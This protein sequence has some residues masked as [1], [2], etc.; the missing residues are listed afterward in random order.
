MNKITLRIPAT[1][2]N[3]GPGFDC[4]GLALNLYNEV[5]YEIMDN[6]KLELNVEGEGAEYM[7]PGGFNLAFSSFFRVWNKLTNGRHIG[8]KLHQVNRIPM[9]RGLGSSSAAIV[10]GV[11]AAS[12]LSDCNLPKDELLRFAN[13]LEGHPDNVAPAIYGNFTISFFEPKGPRSFVLRPAKPLKFIACVPEMK[14]STEVARKAIP[15]KINHKD[16][17]VNAS[18]TALLVAALTSGQYEYLPTAMQDK[19][20]QPYREHL[21]PG[22]RDAFYG[23]RNNGAYNAIIS[24]AGSTIM[25]YADPGKD[26]DAIGAAM[27][28]AL[29]AKGVESKYFIY[30]MDTEGAKLI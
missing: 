12:I 22:L 8:L 6:G 29:K 3:C 4:L 11:L 10:G 1:S 7:Q 27:Q 28:R 21:I 2:A 14:L 30:D 19:L 18:R 26:L 5:T 9:S 16:A 25:A 20:H 15:F 17:V 23:A 13:S 24:G